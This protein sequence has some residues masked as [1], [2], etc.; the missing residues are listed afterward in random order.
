MCGKV[1]NGGG[2]V[3]GKDGEGVKSDM[4]TGEGQEWSDV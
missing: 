3:N 1:E 4:L 2:H